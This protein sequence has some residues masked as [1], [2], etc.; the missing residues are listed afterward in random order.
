MAQNACHENGYEVDPEIVKIFTEYRK[1]HN[2][3]YLMPTH[4]R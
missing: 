4:Q 2:Q 3:V 1:T